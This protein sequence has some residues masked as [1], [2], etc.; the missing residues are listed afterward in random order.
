M[1][2]QDHMIPYAQSSDDQAFS[3]MLEHPAVKAIF[4]RNHPA[5]KRV[6]ADYAKADHADFA[7]KASMNMREFMLIIKDLRLHQSCGMTVVRAQKLFLDVQQGLDFDGDG[8][9]NGFIQL[10]PEDPKTG[11]AAEFLQ[12]SK[13]RK[14]DGKPD[15]PPAGSLSNLAELASELDYN[16]FLLS[17]CGMALFRYPD[18]FLPLY[19]RL[20]DFFSKDLTPVL[21][22]AVK[23]TSLR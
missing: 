3:E 8:E 13:E 7:R 2:V 9:D 17:I 12:H 10:A 11:S 22:G 21:S 6:F 20:E 14:S 1:F 18:P 15:A 23:P 4:L 19:N 16:E 5:L